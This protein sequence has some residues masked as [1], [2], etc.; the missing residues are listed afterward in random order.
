MASGNPTVTINVFAKTQAANSAIG[1]TNQSIGTMSTA[2][3]KGSAG[4]TNLSSSAGR[5]KGQLVGLVAAYVTLRGAM[6]SMR[7][8]VDVN[9]DFEDSM[10]SARAVTEQS[11]SFTEAAFKRMTEEARRLGSTTRFSAGQAAEG[12]KFLGMAGFSADQATQSLNAT[13]LLAQAGSLELGA[14]ADIVSNIMSAFG[15][16]ASE[17]ESYVDILAK[18]AATSNNSI[19]ELGDA[20][21]FAAPLLSGLKMG[22][23]EGAAAFGVLGNAG[24]KAGM[25]GAG[26]RM[27]L[28]SLAKENGP[29]VKALKKLG[30]TYDEINPTAN[31]LA[32][33]FQNLSRKGIDVTKVFSAFDARAANVAQVLIQNADVLGTYTAQLRSSAGAAQEMADTMD[34]T[35]KGA[36]LRAKSAIQ[37]AL[38]S[39]G[40]GF[41]PAIR[42]ASESLAEFV[43]KLSSTGKLEKFGAAMAT[44][45]QILLASMGA[46]VNTFKALAKAPEPIKFALKTLLVLWTL[47]KV[48]ASAFV[49]G[50]VVKAKALG[51]AFFMLKLRLN[52]M[53][54]QFITL[55]ASGVGSLRAIGLAAKGVGISIKGALISTGIGALIV[56]LGMVVEK[57]MSIASKASEAAKGL[58]EMHESKQEFNIDVNIS[59]DSA[60]SISQLDELEERIRERMIEIGK[61]ASAA[62]ARANKGDVIKYTDWTGEEKTVN[63]RERITELAAEDLALM[64]ERLANLFEMRKTLSAELEAERD[65]TIEQEKQLALTKE[66][67]KARKK[68]LDETGKEMTDDMDAS[69]KER[70]EGESFDTQRTVLLTAKWDGDEGAMMARLEELKNK[71]IMMGAGDAGEFAA[72]EMSDEEL[73]ELQELLNLQNEL[74][75][76]EKARKEAG[77]ITR[78]FDAEIEILAAK[79]SGEDALAKVLQRQYDIRKL[80]AQLEKKNVQDAAR[81][82]EDMIDKKNALKEKQK[83]D[84]KEKKEKKERGRVDANVVTSSLQS[85]G[86]GGGTGGANLENSTARTADATE[87]IVENTQNL[88]DKDLPIV[89][90]TIGGSTTLAGTEGATTSA[91]NT[92]H[93]SS[94]QVGLLGSLLSVVESIHEVIANRAAPDAPVIQIS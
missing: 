55:R 46:V 39:V 65:K 58:N 16:E 59:L 50:T 62:Y 78:D 18:T 89:D 66:Q 92:P 25:A 13:L 90:G 28:G 57:L 6:A 64:E 61:N 8:L 40:D 67:L 47:N 51:A 49:I 63:L 17:T 37:E 87:T 80:T 3:T 69:K 34:N 74:E 72:P 35:L 48:A 20:M 91:I 38:L 53:R 75:A 31:S 94:T 82:A 41:V 5:L 12:L 11:A 4:M 9:R 26:L 56:A 79:I 14:A 54:M 10:A 15:A 73:K 85:I 52:S 30:V 1:R 68:L 23:V 44:G 42:S 32:E 86:G 83:N 70:M 84:Q 60:T 93:Q 88:V 21:K 81:K 19:E 2:A 43:N 45:F 71:R 7:A 27:V 29:A 77:D 33:I 76:V 36:F 22:A 24:I